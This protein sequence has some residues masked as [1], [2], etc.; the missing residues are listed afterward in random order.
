MS[1]LEQVVWIPLCN[2]EEPA[3]YDGCQCVTGD[4]LT[5]IACSCSDVNGNPLGDGKALIVDDLIGWENTC[6]ELN[7]ADSVYAGQKVVV[8]DTNTD[9]EV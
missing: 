7:C 2:E 8:V 3:L 1:F 6:R 9:T 5:E 4:K